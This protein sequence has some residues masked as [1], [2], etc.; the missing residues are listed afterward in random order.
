MGRACHPNSRDQALYRFPKL[1][2]LEAARR[3]PLRWPHPT[4]PQLRGHPLAAGAVRAGGRRGVGVPVGEALGD[5]MNLKPPATLEIAL[6]QPDFSL[7][8]QR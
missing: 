8:D 6:P 3:R 7:V 4:M 1:T 5:S 2:F